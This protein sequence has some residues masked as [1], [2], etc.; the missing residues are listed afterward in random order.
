MYEDKPADRWRRHWIARLDSTLVGISESGGSEE[1][2]M[3]CSPNAVG[4]P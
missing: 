4:T 3:A 2:V 1:N